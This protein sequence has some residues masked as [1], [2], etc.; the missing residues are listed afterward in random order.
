VSAILSGVILNLGLHGI[1]RV[2]LDLVPVNMVWAGVTM[3]IVG[4][5]SALVGILYAT[6]END[7]KAML[8]HSSIEN[9]GIVTAG[10][11]AGVIFATYGQ[12]QLAG[13]A[14]IAAFYHLINHSL[15]KALLFLGAGAVDDRAGTHD[16]NKLGGL[17]R[18]MPWTAACFAAGSLSI[19]A[20]PPFKRICERM[21][22][23]ANNAPQRRTIIDRSENRLCS[24]RSGARSH[25]SARCDLLC[26]G[27]CDGI[28]RDGPV[29]PGGESK[30][31][32]ALHDCA[33]G[34]S[35]AVMPAV[36]SAANDNDSRLEELWKSRLVWQR[37]I[38][39]G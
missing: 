22:H 28:S 38:T 30:R 10:L 2:N 11:G 26:E 1:I 39:A 6:I 33:D 36:R 19:A 27:G 32:A 13:I 3:L 16:L 5:I 14:F 8:A 12:V 37:C 35:C 21:A 24:L 31:S 34:P 15:Y 29:A 25:S 20:L 17:I 9:I 23:T 18:R 7:L 4:T